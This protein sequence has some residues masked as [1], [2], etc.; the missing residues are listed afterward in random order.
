MIERYAIRAGIKTKLG[1]H[2]LRATGITDYLKSD[3]SLSESQD[4]EPCRHAH[5]TALRPACRRCLA[6]RIRQGGDLVGILSRLS[7][8][9]QPPSSGAFCLLKNRFPEPC[10]LAYLRAG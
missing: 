5:Y 3:G 4:G 1:N 8:P 7:T 9:P 6:R 10:K 2:S